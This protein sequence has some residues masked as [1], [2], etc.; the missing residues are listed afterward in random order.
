MNLQSKLDKDMQSQ[1]K[2]IYELVEDDSSDQREE[3]STY[4]KGGSS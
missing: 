3:E 4:K 2:K 1:V